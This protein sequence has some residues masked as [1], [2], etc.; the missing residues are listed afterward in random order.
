MLNIGCH[1]SLA[2]G[3]LHMGEDYPTLFGE[4]DMRR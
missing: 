4:H 2:K 1:L 3:Y